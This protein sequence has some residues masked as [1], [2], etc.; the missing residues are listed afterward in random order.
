MNKSLKKRLF[1]A[2]AAVTVIAGIAVIQA[3]YRNGQAFSPDIYG[4]EREFQDNQVVFPGEDSYD[5]MQEDQS[6][7]SDL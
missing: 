1:A 3:S 4:Q 2:A 7:R 5:P 6:G